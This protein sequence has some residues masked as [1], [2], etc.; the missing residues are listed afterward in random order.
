MKQIIA[1]IA[2]LVLVASVHAQTVTNLIPTSDPFAGIAQI[3]QSVYNSAQASGLL[4]KTNY[5]PLAYTTYA[6]KAKDKIGGGAAVAFNFSGLANTN[7]NVGT[8]FGAD[9]LGDWSLVNAS[10]TLKSKVRP[11]NVGALSWLPDSVRLV[12]VEPIAIGGV[13]TSLGGSSAGGTLW[14]I[15]GDIN[16][17]HWQKGV[18]TAGATWGEWTGNTAE[19]GHRYHIFVGWRYAL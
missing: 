10:V 4:S 2:G 18:F 16:F 7:A 6:P 3:A 19:P 5:A 14:D 12:Q 8:L 1:A 9:W 13:W 17:G 15:G 11:L